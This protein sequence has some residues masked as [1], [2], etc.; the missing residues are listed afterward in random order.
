[1]QRA[2]T[3]VTMKIAFRRTNTPTVV[4]AAD[5]VLTAEQRRRVIEYGD[6]EPE[7]AAVAEDEEEPRAPERLGPM[8]GW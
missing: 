5:P 8:S 2:D 6:A 1:L 7:P 4:A 3:G